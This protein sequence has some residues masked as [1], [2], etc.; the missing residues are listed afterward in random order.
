MPEAIWDVGSTADPVAA[1]LD[2]HAQGVLIALRTS[3]TTTRPRSV[4]RTAAS[5]V[6]SFPEVTRLASIDSSSRVWIPGPLSATMNLFAAAHASFVGATVT[7]IP[8]FATHAHLTPAML[9]GCLDSGVDLQGRHVVVAGDRL[10]E[11]LARRA[12]AAGVRTSHYYGAAE[13]SFV[14]WGT[15]EGDL[16]AFPGVDVAIRDGEIWAHSPYLARGYAGEPGPLRFAADGFATVG[17][18]GSLTG[19]VLTVAGRGSSTVI[20][21]G[22]T[23]LVADVERAL[24]QASGSEVFVLGIEHPR[25]GA[26]VTAVL[27]DRTA[28]PRARAAARTQLSRAQRPV[29]WFHVPE[30]PLTDAG[31]VDRAALAD[32]VAAGRLTPLASP[33][34]APVDAS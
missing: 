34:R 16:R 28:H 7:A 24:R 27:T 13:L 25:L 14:A 12:A 10:G 26:L 30:L 3:G 1:V 5:W 33:G 15:H 4:V 2:A 6:R 32:L 31:K 17:D 29:W 23:V 20:T 19:G 22:A 21:A 8:A 9:A 11:G 18:R